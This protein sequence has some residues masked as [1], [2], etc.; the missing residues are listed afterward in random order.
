[1]SDNPTREMLLKE[2][3]AMEMT[4][5]MLMESIELKRRLACMIPEDKTTTNTDNLNSQGKRLRK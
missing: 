4:V 2:A 3:E 1:M 5:K